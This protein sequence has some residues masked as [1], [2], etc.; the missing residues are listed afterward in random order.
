MLRAGAAWG[1]LCGGGAAA[2]ALSCPPQVATRAAVLLLFRQRRPACRPAPSSHCAAQ[3]AP[4]SY[5][6]ATQ[7]QP[8]YDS[9][10][11]RAYEQVGFLSKQCL[12]CSPAGSH[13]P[14]QRGSACTAAALPAA[15]VG[16]ACARARCLAHPCVQVLRR[17]LRM[18]SAPALL[19]LMSYPWW[20]SYGDGISAGLFYRE[21]ETELTV[22]GQASKGGGPRAHM[23]LRLLLQT[24]R[25]QQEPAAGDPSSRCAVAPMP[26]QCKTLQHRHLCFAQS[27]SCESRLAPAAVLRFAGALAAGGR[28]AADAGGNRRLPGE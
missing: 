28:L 6:P 15:A 19:L 4:P 12:Q 9:P 3:P 13:A 26:P 27:T 2:H 1:T 23:V 10:E 11:R 21:P 25:S 20:Q 14:A 7:A 8:S 17:L 16:D 22:L 18:P 5:L 24:G